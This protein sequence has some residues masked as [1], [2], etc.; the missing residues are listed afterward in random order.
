LRFLAD[1]HISRHLIE[2]L[3]AG[4]HDVVAAAESYP[5]H[6]DE[7]IAAIAVA[8]G[9]V[10]ITE[11]TDDGE[12]AVRLHFPL[13]GILLIEMPRT[14]PVRIADRVRS[15]VRMKGP[16]IIGNLV[17]TEPASDRTRPL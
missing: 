15:T 10:V 13:P 1:E 4:G 9:R 16:G 14:T 3:R 12:L 8:E 2:G 7:Q 11:D 5:G 17:V 6:P